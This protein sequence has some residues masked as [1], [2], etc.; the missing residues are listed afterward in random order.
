M[1][2]HQVRRQL[3]RRAHPFGD[4]VFALPSVRPYGFDDLGGW[5]FRDTGLVTG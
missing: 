5:L 3:Q 2:T 4:Y 1:L